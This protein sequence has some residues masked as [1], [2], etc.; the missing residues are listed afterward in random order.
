MRRVPIALTL[1]VALSASGLAALTLDR[2]TPQ[3]SA[4][5]ARAHVV[6][7]PVAIL[8]DETTARR[9]L[10]SAARE[11]YGRVDGLADVRRVPLPGSDRGMIVATAIRWN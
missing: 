8:A 4:S 3:F 7:G 2:G 1:I 6:L 11:R 9:P 10:T 5:P